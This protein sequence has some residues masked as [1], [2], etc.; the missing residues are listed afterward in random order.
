MLWTTFF[1]LVH[2]LAAPSFVSIPW[3]GPEPTLALEAAMG[4]GFSPKP[5]D[6][7]LLREKEAHEI[8]KR[9]D[10]DQTCG[11]IN[12]KSCELCRAAAI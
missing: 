7:P 5:T 12:A 2:V 6:A 1:V 10:S 9:Q 4:K 11:Y 8:F 3:P